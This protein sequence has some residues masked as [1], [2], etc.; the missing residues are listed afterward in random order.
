MR[1]HIKNN[2]TIGT[3]PLAFIKMDE[4]Y[5]MILIASAKSN[6]LKAQLMITS[7]QPHFNFFNIYSFERSPGLDSPQRFVQLKRFL[8]SLT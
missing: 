6:A 7:S 2:R 8:S 1:S 4:G 3:N 5:Q